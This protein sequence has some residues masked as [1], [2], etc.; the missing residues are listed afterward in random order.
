VAKKVRPELA[1]SAMENLQKQ[2]TVII[3]DSYFGA[4]PASPAVAP[5]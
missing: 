3:D 5:K 2:T 1:R 4:P